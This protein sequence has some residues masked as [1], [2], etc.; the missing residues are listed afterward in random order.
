MQRW[1]FFT[2]NEIKP[3]G[4]LKKQL[5]IQSKGQNGNLDK[6]WPD[7]RDSG[8]IGGNAENWERVPCWLDGFVPLAYL[9]ED[10]DMIARAKRYV[11]TI[12]ANQQPDGWICPCTEEERDEYESWPILLIT[13]VLVQYHACTGDERIP[14]VVYGVLKNFYQRIQDGKVQWVRWTKSRW[15]ES[16]FGI[17]FLLERYQEEWI[18]E[19]AKLLKENGMIYGNVLDRWE[20]PLNYS[21]HET[22]SVNI[23]LAFKYEAVSCDIL[24]EPYEDAA[25]KMYQ[26]LQKF[27][28]TPVGAYTGD[29][30]LAGRSPIQG[31]ELCSIVDMMFSFEVLYAYTG[32]QKWAERLEMLA[33]NGLPATIS[34]DMWTHQYDQ[35]S[36]Q[37]ACRRFP[38]KPIF[39][40]NSAEAGMFGLEPHYGCCTANHGQGWPKFT[41][42]SFMHSGNEIIN[43]LPIPTRL[44]CQ[45]AAI[46]LETNYPF[47]NTFRYTVNAKEDF[48]LKIR[49]P[50]FAENLTVD[51]AQ[52]CEKEL[53]FSFTAGENREIF[54][55]FETTPHLV[56]RPHDLKTVQCGSL[57]FSIPIA[58]EKTML[59]YEKDGVERKFPY[60]DY[61]F[62]PASDWNYAYSDDEFAVQRKEIGDVPFSSVNPPVTLTAKVKKINWGLEEGYEEVCAKVPV[63]REPISE[64]QEITLY[65]YGCAKLRMTEIPLLGDN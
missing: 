7:V 64:E 24:G 60:C 46:A 37:I 14:Q 36:N 23:A 54:V 41:V 53:A 19:L 17:K 42:A 11:D 63:S 2:T 3:E 45:K 57:V 33:F 29:E 65:P 47:E 48:V 61:H 15:Y 34:D 31:T 12:I 20:H 32:D 18:T 59:E 40:T 13:K 38:G 21:T 39:R 27:H 4:W 44:N 62:M 30:C 52:V 49:V 10:A 55:Q 25:E 6:M 43:V 35:L 1:H 50:S 5:Q 56:E 8:W 58:I 16:F 51:G 22:H 28:G 9:L 26:K